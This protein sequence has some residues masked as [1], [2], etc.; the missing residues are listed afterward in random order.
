MLWSNIQNSQLSKGSLLERFVLK[1]VSRLYV[2]G[3]CVRRPGFHGDFRVPAAAPN[4]T[5]AQRIRWNLPA[6]NRFVVVT[7]ERFA[8]LSASFISPRGGRHARAC[9][10]MRL[11]CRGVS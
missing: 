1:N 5:D 11:S 6:R 9:I 4:I 3:D 2:G 10:C 8:G 7:A